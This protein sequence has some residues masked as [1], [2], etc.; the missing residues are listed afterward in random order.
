MQLSQHFE[1][2]EFL[3]SKD[4]PDLAKKIVPTAQ[5]V[6]NLQ[7]LAR[8]LERVRALVGRPLVILSGLR[9]PELNSA[10]G[11]KPASD[12]LDGLAADVAV[13]WIPE[14]DFSVL[15][16]RLFRGVPELRQVIV[17]PTRGF[18][19]LAVG[20]EIERR[21]RGCFEGRPDGSYASIET[22]KPRTRTA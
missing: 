6:A 11:G 20:R 1:L 21:A 10:G 9:S 16:E 19:H 4:H 8:A 2:R 13:T 18:A 3:V 14:K 7:R 15:A 12:H 17:Y 22:A 5:Q